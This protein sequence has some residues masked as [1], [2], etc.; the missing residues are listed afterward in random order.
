MKKFIIKSIKMFFAGIFALYSMSCSDFLDKN[1]LDQISS[2]TFWNTEDEVDMA[3]AGVYARLRGFTFTH[4]DGSFDV[5]GG[6]AYGT[7]TTLS[8]GNIE[9][10]SGSLVD[11]IYGD[12][13]KGISTCN[14]FLDNVDMAEFLDATKLNQYKAE[15]YFL[16]A[17]FYFT[18]TDHYG[19]VPLYTNYV[20]V[21]EAL[22]KQSTK[23]QVMEQVLT[24]LDFAITN[25]PNEA[26]SDGHVVKGS[27][28]ALK[29]RV[30]LYN[31]RWSDAAEAAN[32]VISD[33]KYDLFDNF[34]TLFL[35]EGQPNNPEIIFSTR[36]LAPDITN[37]LDIRF[38]WHGIL[39]PN[40]ILVD[41]YECTDGLTI[42]ESPLYDPTNWR[43]NRDPRCLMTIKAYEDKVINSA[44]VEMGFNYNNVGNGYNPVKYCN[45]DVLPIDYS[46]ISDQDW[47]LIRYAEVLLMYAEAKNEASGPDASVYSA[48]NQVRDRVDMPP[49]PE[50]LSKDEMRERIRHERRVELA[51]EGFRWSDVRRWRI[52]E[53]IIPTIVDVGGARRK[54]DPSK[55]YLLPFPQSERD[56]N[57]NLDQ[58]PGY[59]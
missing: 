29:A 4:K 28:Q 18:L 36:Y 50:G 27:A 32:Q 23:E 22:I 8:Q 47:I 25:L 59:N 11:Q 17:L 49:L 34:R 51:L 26:Y 39:N 37:N 13:Y 56:I 43:L 1:P 55:H 10:T 19:G 58:N 40:Q 15:V 38:S 35:T 24:D 45:W 57:P 44:G 41:A 31:E 46:T 21:E 52:A 14:F 48:V 42:D 16:R 54:F 7:V 12:C 2:E 9:P 6:D 3:L 5:M 30:L 33:G 53:D 20:T